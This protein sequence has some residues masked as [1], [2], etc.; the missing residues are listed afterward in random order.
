MDGEL[1][2]CCRRGI[3]IFRDFGSVAIGNLI[4][5]LAD[6]VEVDPGFGVVAVE[7]HR[8][9]VEAAGFADGEEIRKMT[10]GRLGVAGGR[11]EH[12]PLLIR[13]RG[14]KN[15]NLTGGG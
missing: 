11:G 7:W 6:P 10:Q 12:D 4:L 1:W 8:T 9:V 13:R 15:R 5:E 14:G 2:R 3:E